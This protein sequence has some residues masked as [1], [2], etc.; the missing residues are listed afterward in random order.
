MGPQCP[1]SH[2]RPPPLPKG[3]RASSLLPLQGCR[4]VLKNLLNHIKHYKVV[5]KRKKGKYVHFCILSTEPPPCCSCWEQEHLLCFT[6]VP[7]AGGASCMEGLGGT[8][9]QPQEH[10]TQ[11][12]IL[13]APHPC[14]FTHPSLQS[15]SRKEAETHGGLPLPGNHPAPQHNSFLLPNSQQLTEEPQILFACSVPPSPNW[16]SSRPY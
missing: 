8:V 15:V 9:L 13:A 14:S 6:H 1:A 2:T 10:I 16:I 4:E 5:K 7:A 3:R 12:H 11:H